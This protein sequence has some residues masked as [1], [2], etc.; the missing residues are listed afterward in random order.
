MLMTPGIEI[1]RGASALLGGFGC[2]GCGTACGM[3]TLEDGEATLEAMGM[4]GIGAHG[5]TAVG[6]VAAGRTTV[7]C[8]GCGTTRKAATATAP[9]PTRTAAAAISARALPTDLAAARGVASPTPLS[10]VGMSVWLYVIVIACS[11]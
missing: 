3:G 6:L 1:T 8:V 4:G 10:W 2:V 11:L 5:E 9:N 7:V